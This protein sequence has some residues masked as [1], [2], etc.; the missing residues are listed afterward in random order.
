MTTT[1]PTTPTCPIPPAGRTRL[2]LA[3][4]L[5]ALGGAAAWALRVAAQDVE[6]QRDIAQVATAWGMNACVVMAAAGA[7]ALALPLWKL[8]GRKHAVQILLVG[9]GAWLIAGLAPRTHRIFFDE[10]IYMQVGQTYAH[11]GRLANA[12]HAN[13]EHGLFEWQNG[14]LN[15]QPQGWPYLYGQVSRFL[16]V[17]PALGQDLNRL[18][19][20]LT[21]AF[22]C[23]ALL[24]SPWRLPPAAP[25]CAGLAWAITPL[26]P[27]WG[28]TAAVEPFSAATVAGAFCAAMIYTR[29]RHSEKGVVRGLPAAGAL[30]AA[31]TA[32]AGYFR[33][34]SLLAFP[35]VAAVL[36]AEED[37]FVRD[38]TAWGTLAFALALV[39]PNLSQLW[40]VRTEDWGATDGQ[41][42][43]FSLI[44]KNLE[45][46]LGYFLKG[47]EF[48]LAG[49]ALAVAGCCWLLA[50]A[51][52]AAVVLAAW[53]LPA[54]GIFVLFY[55]GGYYYGA[56]NR[57][58]VISAAPVAIAIGVAAGVLLSWGLKRP[59]WLGVAAGAIAL[60][61][62]ASFQFV[63]HLGHEALEVQQEVHFVA[64]QARILP[65][66][67]L[68]VSQVP[69]MW[70]IEGRNS[71]AWFDVSDLAK[72]HL[73][74]LVNQYPGG[75]YFHYGYWEHVEKGRADEAA[76][77]LLDFHAKEIAR[78]TSHAMN[79]ALFRLDTPEA[80]QLFGGAP[81]AY[82]ARRE[83]ELDNSLDRARRER[84][85]AAPGTP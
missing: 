82:P 73:R 5:I 46:N 62:A 50:R 45:S 41:R 71:A 36:W 27:W 49:T 66:G 55:A 20:G 6:A 42:F 39:L 22:L 9:I 26:V 64:E 37:D 8:L 16:G 69:S 15:K 83:G 57:Y 34:E 59:A 79:F 43:N 3:A 19:V 30:L 72:T 51:R 77:I 14:R 70:M 56:S 21:G 32:F 78:F 4:G 13:A 33:P 65:A 47:K 12:S 29:L 81:S 17:S 74:E 52:S 38:L 61:W 68:V 2:W 1:S 48:P 58:A 67:S 76:G 63:P 23:M 28:R 84:A 31:A 75:V 10:Q 40:S 11:T 85:A 80:I 60:N 25:A 44:G 35:L 7:C 54:W 24:L 18:S 53:F